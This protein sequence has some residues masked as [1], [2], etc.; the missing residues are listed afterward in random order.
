MFGIGFTEILIILIV[1]LVIIGPEKLPELT[2][3]IGKAFNEFKRTSNDIKR[4]FDGKAEGE[5]TEKSSQESNSSGLPDDDEG[6]EGDEIEK[7]KKKKATTKKAV[8][9][10]SAEKK[11]PVKKA[12]KKSPKKSSKNSNG[13]GQS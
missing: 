8:K 10:K 7:P 12:S 1:A 9:P 11:K 2:K 3:T 6:E 13:E 4:T 5:S